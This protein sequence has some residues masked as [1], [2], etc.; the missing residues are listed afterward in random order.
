MGPRADVLLEKWQNGCA[1]GSRGHQ[2]PQSRA[3]QTEGLIGTWARQ[4]ADRPHT[5]G[6]SRH[7]GASA[8]PWEALGITW[9]THQEENWLGAGACPWRG[10][11]QLQEGVRVQAQ[12]VPGTVARPNSEPDAN[13]WLSVQW[14]H[15]TGEEISQGLSFPSGTTQSS[16]SWSLALQPTGSYKTSFHQP[17][18][19]WKSQ[20][21]HSIGCE[22][23]RKGDPG[24]L[25]LLTYGQTLSTFMHEKHRNLPPELWKHSSPQT[26]ENPALKVKKKICKWRPGWEGIVSTWLRAQWKLHDPE[27]QPQHSLEGEAEQGSTSLSICFPSLYSEWGYAKYRPLRLILRIIRSKASK[28]LALSLEHSSQYPR[29]P[30]ITEA[31]RNHL[32]SVRSKS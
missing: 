1:T 12:F 10:R 14:A 32:F 26:A 22:V 9:Q 15:Q 5:S 27:F 8:Q 11:W 18:L 16:S 13:S 24:E 17:V 25:T 7:K 31:L 29:A 4:G 21:D 30:M 19:W 3:A 2:D 6:S 20:E 28:W 23:D